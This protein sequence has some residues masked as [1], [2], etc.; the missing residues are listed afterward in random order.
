LACNVDRRFGDALD[1]LIVVDLRSAPAPRLEKYLGRQ[2][3]LAFM[4]RHLERAER[5]LRRFSAAEPE[6]NPPTLADARGK[7]GQIWE[8][9]KALSATHATPGPR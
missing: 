1:A 5:Y 8:K 2:G 4:A 3:Y 7:L 9:Q 6:G